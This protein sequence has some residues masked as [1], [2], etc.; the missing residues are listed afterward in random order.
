M[1]ADAGSKGL[2]GS[3]AFL[4]ASSIDSTTRITGITH[5][6]SSLS[7]SPSSPPAKE[8]INTLIALLTNPSEDLSVLTALFTTAPATLASALLSFGPGKFQ[9]EILDVLAGGVLPTVG[10]EALALYLEFFSRHILS[11]SESVAVTMESLVFFPLVL[12]TKPRQKKAIVAWAAL[13]KVTEGLDMFRGCASIVVGAKSGGNGVDT[14]R[15]F[16]YDEMVEVN[17]KVAT[18]IAGESPPTS[19]C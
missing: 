3:D 6:L 16:S 4:A 2:S 14:E 9:S 10:R 5:I 11:Y 13:A 12:L 17:D 18:Q 15:S 1:R 19:L 7:S 8:Q